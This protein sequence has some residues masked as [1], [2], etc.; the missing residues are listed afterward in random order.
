MGA[1]VLHAEDWDSPA[2]DPDLKSKQV[3]KLWRG[4][5]SR[6]NVLSTPPRIPSKPLSHLRN[7]GRQHA[8]VVLS[9]ADTFRMPLAS[10]SNTTLIC[11]TPRGAGGMPLSSNLPSRLLSRV[12][13]RSPS[14]TCPAPC[15]QSLCGSRHP[16]CLLIGHLRAASAADHAIGL[17]R[18]CL[19]KLIYTVTKAQA[20]AAIQTASA[21]LHT[22]HA[23]R[24]A[25]AG[26]A[27]LD[28]DAG[29]VVA[30]RAEHLLLLRRDGG[31]ARDQRRLCAPA[32]PVSAHAC[33]PMHVPLGRASVPCARAS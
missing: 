7:A 20:L 24:P 30:V 28:Q 8:P 29:L 21:R 23:G 13:D 32:Q 10:M 11:G 17:Q 27:R 2:R 4:G 6:D 31:V 3:L 9:S 25:L 33:A 14:Y 12:R 26:C 19:P 16:P 1:V 15:S 18:T 22:G 5:A